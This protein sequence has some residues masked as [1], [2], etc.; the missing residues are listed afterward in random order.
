MTNSGLYYHTLS[1]L[2]SALGKRQVSVGL[3]RMFAS[4]LGCNPPALGH[5]T[6]PS[7]NFFFF[8]CILPRI[9][10]CWTVFTAV[11]VPP[12][13]SS[14]ASSS[15]SSSG[16]RKGISEEV[17]VPWLVQ[18]WLPA[19]QLAV[20]HQGR[21]WLQKHITRVR[22]LLEEWRNLIITGL[23]PCHSMKLDVNQKC[24]ELLIHQLPF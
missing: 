24:T 15:P 10:N 17:S 16:R 4:F 1:R 12:L 19:N 5:S 2:E 14:T 9:F 13:L 21:R 20:K 7:N 22:P 11:A 8:S 23:V 3:S 6:V 18:S